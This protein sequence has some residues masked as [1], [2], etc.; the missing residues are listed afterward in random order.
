MR[1]LLRRA[2]E[3]ELRRLLH[4]DGE[5]VSGNACLALFAAADAL[6][7]GFV[8]G[9]P[10]HVYVPHLGR[11]DLAAWTNLVPA[12]RG[13][14]PDVILRAAPAP[15]S[16]FRGLVPSERG[17]A[18]DIIQVW[19]DVASH[20]SRGPEQAELIRRRVLAPVI[21]GRHTGHAG[22]GRG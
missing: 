17:P 10:P 12:E 8:H 20:P 15:Q 22:N 13:E 16:V 18:S 3:A 19:L 2:P 1:F 21:D 5:R 4:R 7:L 14:A 6:G 9:V 11:A